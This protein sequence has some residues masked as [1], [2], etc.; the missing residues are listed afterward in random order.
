MSETATGTL[1]TATDLESMRRQLEASGDYR[2]LRRLGEVEE[3]RPPNDAPKYV[4]LYLDTET[5]GFDPERDKIIELA[6][7]AFEYD[8]EGNVYRIVRSGTQLEDPGF[9]LSDD[10]KALT[11]ITDEELAGRRI[12]E[13]E[14]DELIGEAR[15]VI[16]HNAG[17]DRP[18]VEKRLP[19]FADLPWA[20]SISDVGWRELGFGSAG[21]EYLAY[22]HGFFFDGHRAL[23]DCRAGVEILADSLNGT[24]RPTM[25][26]LRDNALKNSVR[27]WAE[28][29]P[30]DSK[31]RLKERRYRWNAEARAWWTEVAEEEHE[32]EL[33]WLAQNVYRRR[34][35]LPYFR[36]TAKE[37]FSRRVPDLIPADAERL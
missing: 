24:G 7:V 10:V 5:T 30:F 23:V 4:A 26:L 14:V 29:S 18:F 20:C 34:A 16:A 1:P 27:I 19:R 9:P 22:K 17:F 2:V 35:A 21:M 37:R 15:L 36:V 11:G 25:A 28:G 33:E 32:A 3:Y 13:P 31:E 6:L 8:L 12:S